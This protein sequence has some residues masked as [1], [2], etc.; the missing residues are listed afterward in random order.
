MQYLKM[1]R[2][3]FARNGGGD[4]DLVI[5]GVIRTLSNILGGEKLFAKTIDGWKLLVF[6]QK[7]SSLMFDNVLS[8]PLVIIQLD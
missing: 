4:R 1:E 7:A 2:M 6:P 3:F 5:R 8:P